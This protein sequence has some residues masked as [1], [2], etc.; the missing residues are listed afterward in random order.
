MSST[1]VQAA[2]A[3]D[4]EAFVVNEDRFKEEYL[5]PIIRSGRLTTLI[6]AILT[7]LPLLYLW[8][9]LGLRPTWDQIMQGWLNILAIYFIIYIR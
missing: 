9:G 8:L 2:T 4:T 5:S 7:C 3:A 1:H 6:A